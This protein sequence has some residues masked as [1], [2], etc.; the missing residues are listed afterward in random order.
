MT[1]KCTKETTP[2]STVFLEVLTVN[3]LV[4]KFPALYGARDFIT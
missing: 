3:Q 1:H 4:N 2:W